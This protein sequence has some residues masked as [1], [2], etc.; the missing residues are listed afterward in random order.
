MTA[1]RYGVRPAFLLNRDGTQVEP[2]RARPDRPRGHTAKY[3]APEYVLY[4]PAQI[5][6]DHAL[7]ISDW[8]Y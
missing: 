2:G 1:G 5:D 3:T 4:G 7:S 6:W 8:M